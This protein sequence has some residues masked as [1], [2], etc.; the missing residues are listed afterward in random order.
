M[1]RE[2]GKKVGKKRPRNSK[3][4]RKGTD[5][6]SGRAQKKRKTRQKVEVTTRGTTTEWDDK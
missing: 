3:K 1:F 6:E 2:K 5:W 4:L